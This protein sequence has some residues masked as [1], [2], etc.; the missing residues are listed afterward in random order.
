MDLLS[1][2]KG[3]GFLSRPS[4]G[5][6]QVTQLLHLGLAAP[7]YDSLTEHDLPNLPTTHRALLPPRVRLPQV[8]VGSI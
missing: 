8:S 1:L 7:D 4:G 6:V 2:D 5:A 3:S